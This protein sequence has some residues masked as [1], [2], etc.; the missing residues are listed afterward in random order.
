MT[1][2]SRAQQPECLMVSPVM[3]PS[4]T[5]CHCH[6]ARSTPR[7]VVD[8]VTA[9]LCHDCYVGRAEIIKLPAD[10]VGGEEHSKL[11]YF[12]QQNAWQNEINRPTLP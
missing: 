5:V 7:C 10:S 1:V 8:I 4:A 6:N 9:Q 2:Q 11:S 12:Q 3:R